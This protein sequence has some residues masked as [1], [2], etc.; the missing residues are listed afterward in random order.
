[1]LT[2]SFSFARLVL[3]GGLVPLA[4]AGCDP[5]PNNCNG[6]GLNTA[7]GTLIG[8]AAGAALGD[9]NHERYRG[10]IDKG[11]GA[12]AGAAIGNSVDN[13]GCGRRYGSSYQQYD[14]GPL[15]RDYYY[16]R[17]EPRRY[18]YDGAGYG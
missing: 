10:S 3:L 4:L 8:A 11:T 18:Y 12:V 17:P 7:S 5:N 6:A 15:P 13:Q 14:Y 9:G 16:E 2:N 1:M